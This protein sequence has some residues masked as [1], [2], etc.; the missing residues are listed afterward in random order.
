M[1]NENVTRGIRIHFAPQQRIRCGLLKMVLACALAGGAAPAWASES[2]NGPICAEV[3]SPNAVYPALPEVYGPDVSG[4]AGVV[5]YL[6]ED[7]AVVELDGCFYLADRP[8][9][10][11]F[12]GLDFITVLVEMPDQPEGAQVY[13]TEDNRWVETLDTWGPMFSYTMSPA[14]ALGF[15]I[16]VPEYAAP[17]GP[18]VITKPSGGN[19]KP[20]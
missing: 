4:E 12:G 17:T 11:D 10:I 19:P 16:A 15:E 6:R 14:H 5:I 8:L 13:V 18:V 3:Y 9:V 1:S 7:H 2:R 20:K